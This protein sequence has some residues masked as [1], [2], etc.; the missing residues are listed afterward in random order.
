[1]NAYNPI[2]WKKK[3]LFGMATIVMAAGV[4]ELVAGSMKYPDAETVAVR[5]QVIAAQSERA[6]QIRDLDHGDIRVAE[7]PEGVK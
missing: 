3:A 6:A 2:S 7:L 4:L 1:M 5:Q